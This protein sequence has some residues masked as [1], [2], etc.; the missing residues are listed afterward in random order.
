MLT[1]IDKKRQAIIAAGH[2]CQGSPKHPTCRAKDGQAHPETD[3]HTTLIAF[4]LLPGDDE[5]MVVNCDRC[6]L[7]RDFT[8]AYRTNDWRTQR[9]ALGNGELFPIEPPGDKR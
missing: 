1:I 2:R 8:A 3:K 5:S 7:T 6:F 4:R 9:A